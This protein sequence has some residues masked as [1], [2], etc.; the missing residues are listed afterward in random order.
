MMAFGIGGHSYL[1]AD[2]RGCGEQDAKEVGF[3]GEDLRA[4]RPAVHLAQ[5]V[6]EGL[7]GGALLFRPLPEGKAGARSSRRLIGFQRLVPA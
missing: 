7:A 2:Q 1:L 3:A 6:A 5:E 4:L